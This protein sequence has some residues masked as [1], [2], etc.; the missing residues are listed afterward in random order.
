MLEGNRLSQNRLFLAFLQIFCLVTIILSFR[1]TSAVAEDAPKNVQISSGTNHT[2]A[3]TKLGTLI[4]W[5]DN[6]A[7][8]LDVPV[9]LKQVTQVEANGN[10]TCVVDT[11]HS[12]TCW[13]AGGPAPRLEPA[14]SVSGNGSVGCIVTVNHTATC[15]GSYSMHYTTYSGGV[16]E[17]H[18][19]VVPP[20]LGQ[21]VQTTNSVSNF[22]YYGGTFEC[23]LKL[24]KEVACW[25]DGL[26]YRL[27][28]ISIQGVTQM[29]QTDLHT[30]AVDQ[31]GNLTCWGGP[32]STNVF[33]WQGLVQ[34][35]TITAPSDLG[36]VVQVD[37]GKNQDC[38]VANQGA[39]AC[40]DSTYGD[41]TH[42]KASVFRSP[43]DLGFVTQVSTQDNSACALNDEDYV[44]CWDKDSSSVSSRHFVGALDS[45]S[46][47][48]SPT[49]GQ[50]QKA[51]FNKW[52]K[53]ASYLYAW[54]SDGALIP[55]S[56]E[57]TY[58]PG[59]DDIGR[60]LS[61]KICSHRDLYEDLCV[62][63][64]RTS[65][66]KN[67]LFGANQKA[68]F[69][70]VPARV[71][72]RIQVDATKLPTGVSVK[73]QWFR[74]DR[75][76]ACKSW[77]GFVISKSDRGHFIKL[78]LELNKVGYATMTQTLKTSRVR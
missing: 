28:D 65:V 31:T 1:P 42:R 50:P 23:A 57:A 3:I 76:I 37:A 2:C 19:Y 53:G 27:T 61:V 6:S 68:R 58:V 14:L 5:G 4:C 67:A 21:I 25:G 43:S 8:Q 16:Y 69:R 73:Y 70:S 20:N 12:V 46:V 71:G 51:L 39:V 64:S 26:S 29:S 74:D 47:S 9:G 78:K 33:Y 48:G 30:C 40:W 24:N 18:P 45:P 52:V 55:N 60:T 22:N 38:A 59:A 44:L 34:G 36:A 72:N 13:G 10:S 41:N 77:N 63:S 66:I 62:T 17:E 11:Q 35:A 75:P 7:G 49:F 56:N 32:Y 54:Y 15:W